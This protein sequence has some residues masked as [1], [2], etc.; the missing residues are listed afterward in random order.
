MTIELTAR[1]WLLFLVITALLIAGALAARPALS[2]HPGDGP[3][4]MEQ[5]HDGVEYAPVN[6]QSE[7]GDD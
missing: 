6:E 4:R 5:H 7:P 2:I 3:A 1:R